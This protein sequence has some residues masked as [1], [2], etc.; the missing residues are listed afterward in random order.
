LSLK[1]ILT[2]LFSVIYLPIYT[3]YR[4]VKRYF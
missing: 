3:L 4:L 1:A 2:V